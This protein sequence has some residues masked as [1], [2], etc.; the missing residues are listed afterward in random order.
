MGVLTN[1]V[2][3]YGY[4][5]D[6]E[7]SKPWLIGTDESDEDDEDY[8][9][10]DEDDWGTRYARIKGV[11]QTKEEYPD[12]GIDPKTGRY[13]EDYTPEE[14]AIVDRY[15]AFL[16]AKH[17]LVEAEPCDIDT[18]CSDECPMPLVAIKASVVTNY[19]GSMTP[20]NVGTLNIGEGWN[21]QL[22]AFCELMDIDTEA[23][24][25]GWYLVS[26]WG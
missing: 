6:E 12:K 23:Q 16:D 18:H 10:D 21:E 20:V 7:T 24:E 11:V 8:N 15:K 22:A 25:P 4:V 9:T 17:K 5:W 26:Y 19:R 13:I 14:Q 2:L 1:A 3:F